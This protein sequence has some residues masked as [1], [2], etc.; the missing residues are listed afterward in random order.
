M[1]LETAFSHAVD[2]NAVLFIGAGFS[3][4]SRN[5]LDETPA[6]SRG[7]A[8]ELYA[9]A[10]IET[11]D[12]NLA[13]A[14]ELY[15]QEWPAG[16]LIEHLKNS[17][18][19]KEPS[20][21]H[22]QFGTIN[23][24]R[25]YTTNY[26]D[27]MK[28]SAAQANISLVPAVLSDRA[29][30]YLSTP[31]TILHINGWIERLTSAS[32]RSDFKLT[33]GSY[34]TEDF[35]RS[36]W[37]TV[38][39]DDLRLASAVIFVGYSMYD[40]DIKRIVFSEKIKE[41]TVFVTSPTTDIVTAKLL[42]TFG[43]VYSIGVDAAAEVLSAVKQHHQPNQDD[44]QYLALRE[45]KIATAKNDITNR[46]FEQLFLY[47]FVS[48][49]LLASSTREGR[50]V[51]Y[52]LHRD[53]QAQRVVD[54]IN[55]GEKNV[56]VTSDLGNG[57]SLFIQRVS[58]LLIDLGWRVFQVVDASA[59]TEKEIERL[60]ESGAKVVFV[61]DSYFSFI[62]II[63][64]ISMRRSDKPC[65]ILMAG[66]TH[67]HEGFVTRLTK[68]LGGDDW[69]EEDLNMLSREDEALMISLMNANG[70][71]GEMAGQSDVK[72]SRFIREN[73]GSQI[74][75]ILIEIFK[76]PSIA[77]RLKALIDEA[78]PDVKKLM[79]AVSII[80]GIGESATPDFLNEVL[81][82]SPL[83]RGRASARPHLDA[84]FFF[85]RE[86]IGLK[87]PV[88]AL[89]YLTHI[90]DPKVILETILEMFFNADRVRHLSASCESF[91]RG[92]VPYSNIQRLFPERQRR[93]VLLSFYSRISRSTFVHR[94]PHY[95]LQY[96][97]ARLAFENDAVKEMDEISRYFET[98]YGH[99]KARVQFDT[100]RIDNHYARFMLFK[101]T[102]ARSSE[103]AISSFRR[104]AQIIK[105]QIAREDRHYPYRVA[106]GVLPL[107]ERFQHEWTQVELREFL[108]FAQ[109]IT[110][111]IAKMPEHLRRH[112]HVK[113]CEAALRTVLDNSSDR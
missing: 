45:Y 67:I 37:C 107:F 70:L 51:E 105:G 40:L 39:R 48:P 95:W 66:R 99:A 11:T 50:S 78:D 36:E 3:F 53:P 98:A 57:K 27:L 108:I 93:E 29:L 58:N 43:Q 62:D 13:N 31:R 106:A 6:D 85:G 83:L 110:A 9:K 63:R 74:S 82:E 42:G 4:G 84:F 102:H 22:L 68:A 112:V 12:S 49:E 101:A 56:V 104:A 89:Y 94:N 73:C 81:S 109:E 88:L 71:W 69:G 87:S 38:F 2:G 32:L 100:S 15:L 80:A 21:S 54:A 1:D 19:I 10:G 8:R 23:W 26:D 92:I 55:Q 60:L 46:D 97:I 17:Y 79:I 47:G 65:S 103:E 113:T 52:L 96:A 90:A 77:T 35:L 64:F 30:D 25:I 16:D 41:K 72:K 111:Q 5:L 91:L 14:S 24:R 59:D 61:F 75:Q 44:L 86:G 7:L 20:S 28:R 18:T 76:S 33:D 34:L